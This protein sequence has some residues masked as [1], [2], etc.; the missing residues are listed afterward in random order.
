MHSECSFWEL[1]PVKVFEGSGGVTSVVIDTVREALSIIR[2][3]AHMHE[4][5]LSY[6]QYQSP[7]TI[8]GTPGRPAFYIPQQQLAYLLEKRFNCVQIA[9]I[10]GVFLR[11]V[12]RRI[13]E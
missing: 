9:K 2:N 8:N 1:V 6:S 10:L 12:R 3:L 5:R 4:A 7:V 13:A 11:T